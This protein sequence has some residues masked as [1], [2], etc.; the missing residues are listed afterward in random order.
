MNRGE[1]R[2]V[3]RLTEEQLKQV[4]ALARLCDETDGITLKLNLDMLE[5]RDPE[6]TNDWLC[7]ADGRIVGFL[8][9]YVFTKKE[10]EISGMVHPDYRK[11]GVFAELLKAAAEESR[12]RGIPELLLIVQRGS[13]S[14][15]AFAKGVGSDYRFSEYGME[16]AEEHRGEKPTSKASASRVALRRALQA[17]LELAARMDAEGFGESI[18]EARAFVETTMKSEGR[19]LWIAELEGVPIGK[20]TI[21]ESGGGFIY[22]FTVLPAFR[23]QGHGRA[24]L[25][26]AIGR[27]LAL[28]LPGRPALEVAAGNDRALGLYKS[29]GFEERSVN[30]YYALPVQRAIAINR[31]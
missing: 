12:R 14:G 22:G 27:I 24:I 30:D 29:L 17:D 7:V 19:Q 10:A 8:G 9:M 20:L 4:K 3:N 23:G 5:E 13:E 6:E 26:Q 15:Q 31:P 1:I 28:G 2:P 21:L 16:L 11:R 25:A 18:E